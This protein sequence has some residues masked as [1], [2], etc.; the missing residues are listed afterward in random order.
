MN[1]STKPWLWF[2]NWSSVVWNIVWKQL[3]YRIQIRF[4]IAY[5][6]FIAWSQS[7]NCSFPHTLYPTWHCQK[8]TLPML[9]PLPRMPF[10]L[11]L[12]VT[13]L[14]TQLTYVSMYLQA[15]FLLLVT[16]SGILGT[17]DKVSQFFCLYLP[18]R[19]MSFSIS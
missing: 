19:I 14:R 13:P 2:S 3:A 9:L 10:T 6:T 7:H 5:K 8:G 1:G 4:S 16:A 15:G 17:Y 11:P 12:A 18:T